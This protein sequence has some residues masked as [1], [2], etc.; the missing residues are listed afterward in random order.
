[1]RGNARPTAKEEGQAGFGLIEAVVALAVLAIL[2]AVLV[3]ATAAFASAERIE[4]SRSDLGR[5]EGAFTEFLTDVEQCAAELDELVYP[6]QNGDPDLIGDNY[7]R[8]SVNRWDGPYYHLALPATGPVTGVGTITG[9]RL[10]ETAPDSIPGIVVEGDI[11]DVLALD[12]A[13]DSGDGSATGTV[14]WSVIS[15]D[16]VEVE[17]YM[18]LTCPPGPGGPPGGGPP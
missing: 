13:V 18:P 17:Y 14:R 8:G 1:M 15:S 2:A 3:P 11:Y 16:Q 9:L 5:V 4:R 10:V 6:I 12:R 7:N